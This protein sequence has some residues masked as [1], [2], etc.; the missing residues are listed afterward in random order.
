MELI[1]GCGT[2]NESMML[3]DVLQ[4]TGLHTLSTSCWRGVHWWSSM[5]MMLEDSRDHHWELFKKKFY[6][7]FFPDSVRYAKEVEFL[8]LMQ[9]D[10]S[11]SEYAEK[12]KHLGRFHTLKMAE[13]WQ[14]RKFENGLRVTSSSW[15]LPLYQ[16]I[17]CLGREGGHAIDAARWA[18]SSRIAQY[19]STVSRPSSQHH[20]I[21]RGGARPQA[22]GR[23][24]AVTGA[25]AAGSGN[26]IIGSCVIAG[27]SLHVLFDSAT[28]SFVS[29]SR[30]VEL[31]LPVKELQYDLVV[32]TPASGLVRTSTV[33][34]RCKIEV[35]GRKYRVN[36]I[37]LPLVGL[38]VILGWIGYLPITFSLTATKGK[39]RGPLETPVV[40]DFSDVFPEDV[41]GL[42]P[43]REIEFS[44]DLVPGAGPVSIAPYRMAPA[45][46]V[47]LKKQIEELLEKQ[48]IRPSVSPWGAP[49]LL[50]KKKDGSSRLCVD[51]RQLNKLTIKN[52]YPLPRIDD[53]M[54]QLHGAAVF[55]K[56]DLRSGYHQ[57]RVKS[58]DVQKTAFRS[59]PFLDKFVVVF[60]DD[61]LITPDSRRT[62]GASE[63]SSEHT[64]RE[65]VVTIGDS[66]KDS[67]DSS[68]LDPV[69]R[70][71]QPFAW[72]DRCEESFL[73][74][75]QKLTSAPVLVIPDTG[76]PFEVYCDASS[77]IG[78]C[79]DARTES[80]GIRL[81]AVEES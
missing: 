78:M 69:T 41:P 36:L 1:S 43:T 34:A 81:T 53:L 48:F 20:H 55:S 79:S 39:L 11:V 31:G 45:E 54:D 27:R 52:K 63:D 8:Q 24:Y 38:D 10:M 18:T 7:E 19:R 67:P 12:F 46:L 42:P 5:K 65:A 22:A 33:C 76:K 26:L 64:E 70:K 51:Y 77:G 57:I 66:L 35:E 32:S 68:T 50:V 74:L 60:I 16:G 62:C 6:A 37:C 3:R 25:E 80:G 44:I 71:D 75:K 49:V 56:I 14:C 61:I 59:R 2:W 72:T 28:H 17:P 13:D 21:T 58:D 29:E 15:W 23:V 47:E 73:K 30:V 9:G 4:R 40:G